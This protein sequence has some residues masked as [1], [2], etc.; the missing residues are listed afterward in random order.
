MKLIK[1]FIAGITFMVIFGIV[2]NLFL[3]VGMEWLEYLLPGIDP[4]INGGIGN[5]ISDAVGVVAG[6]SISSI[7]GKLLKVNEEDTTFIQQLLGVIIG[8]L[9]PIIIY[10]L[11]M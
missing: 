4:T 3:I 6:A 11:I 1:P 10:I 8:C 5:T 2:D 7:V 9:I